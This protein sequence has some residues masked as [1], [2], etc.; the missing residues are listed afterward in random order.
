MTSFFESKK[1]AAV[2]KHA[3][4]DA[5][6]EP[7][8]MKTGSTSAG[9]RVAFIDGY[10]GE[11][12]YAD[13]SDG[14]PALVLA[15]AKKIARQR[16]LECF[17]V[18]DD[19]RNYEQLASLVDSEG[20][21]CVV[22]ILFGDVEQ[23]LQGLITRTR[24][25]PLLVFLD[26]FGLMLPMDRVLEIFSRPG[27]LGSP[28]TE[29]L[30]NFSAVA[31]RRIA[32]H[33]ASQTPSRGTLAQMDA[34]C[35]GDWWRETWSSHMPD[36]TAAEAAVVQGYARRL[37]TAAK[38]GCWTADIRNKAGHKPVYYLVFLSRH[39]HGLVLFGD[40]LSR[41]TEKWRRAAVAPMDM[42]DGLFDPEVLFQESE[43]ALA[44]QWVDAIT[45]NLR[46]LLAGGKAFKPVDKYS[47]VYGDTAGLAREK[48]LRAAW[49][50]LHEE[51]VTPTDS[52]GPLLRK[53]I[54][55]A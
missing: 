22:C 15:K 32:G 3:V 19:M 9:G 4:L 7:F 20:D 27:G 11:G 30:I 28:A 36:S 42:R 45:E 21:N 10:A 41:G 23:H 2:L 18:E 17:F 53:W 13:G 44:S 50:R 38:S 54:H 5:Y 16:Q 39:P 12:R 14:S 1:A 52:K 46:S 24:G 47:E 37:K 43:D 25:I 35:G 34:V 26:P 40:A 33:L 8:A 29:V 48:H 31:L 51:G 6:I 55:P 49:K